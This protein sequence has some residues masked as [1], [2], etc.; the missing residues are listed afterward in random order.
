MSN[1]L[2]EPRKQRFGRLFVFVSFAL[3]L[4]AWADPHLSL[5][6][7]SGQL[8]FAVQSPKQ[9]SVKKGVGIPYNQFSDSR[10]RLE[11]LHLNWFYK[12]G[13]AVP[14]DQPENIEFVPMIA[15]QWNDK[16]AVYEL[17]KAGNFQTLLGFNEPD[18]VNQPNTVE[19]AMNSW[20]NLMD[21]GLRLGSPGC[22]DA[23]GEWMQDFMAAATAA[24]YRVDFVAVHKYPSSAADFLQHIQEVHEM[25]GLPIWITEFAISDKYADTPE[26][27][28][29][30]MA[31]VI[32]VLESLD[33]VER[34]A[35]VV[36]KETTWLKNSALFNE[37]G[38]MTE[39]G[40][41]YSSY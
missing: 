34:Y 15:A 13:H 24:E 38:S 36:L 5:P 37:D 11:N 33:Y 12:W 28:Y 14:E 29:Q 17:L 6:V 16:P 30:F 3:L 20:T 41:L 35:W 18:W 39:L 22:Y 19:Y 32:P 1:F 40:K 27:V 31:A 21:T 10:E 23:K 8:L 4:N 9:Y 7:V 26:K 2:R 25:Y